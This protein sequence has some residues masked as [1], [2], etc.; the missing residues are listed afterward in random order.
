MAVN[1]YLV[2]KDIQ[3]PSTSKTGAIDCLS[4]SFGTSQTAT[5]GVGASGMESKAGRADFSNLTI[6]KVLDK[7][8]P[9]LFEACVK[10]NVLKSVVLYYDK[11]VGGKQADYFK[12]TLQDA[13]VTSQQLSGSSENPSESISF[14]FQCVEIA[15]AAEKDDGTLDSFV[16]KGFSLEK[17]DA[18]ASS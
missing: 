9:A 6:M 12:I 1:A 4:F 16:P 8:S 2:I 15:Y 3:G 10:A 14:A 13:I 5:Y 11:P 18:W 7:T 17:L